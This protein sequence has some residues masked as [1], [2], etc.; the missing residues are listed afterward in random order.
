MVTD[1]KEEGV[2]DPSAGST[3]DAVVNSAL[4]GSNRDAGAS[5]ITHL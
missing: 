4:H 3:G 1:V 5:I 2:H